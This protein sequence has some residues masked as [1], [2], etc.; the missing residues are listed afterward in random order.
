MTGDTSRHGR[1]PYG[2][3]RGD[4]DSTTE[5]SPAPPGFGDGTERWASQ[6]RI[7]AASQLRRREHWLRRQA[8]DDATMCG[9][10]VDHA[11]RRSVITLTTV[12][13]GRHTGIAVGAGAEVVVLHAGSTRI[14]VAIDAVATVQAT[15]IGHAPVNP[16]G[17]RVGDDP[18]TMA[19]LL[20]HA[21][22]DRPEITLVTRGGGAVE[23]E[24]RA[25]GRDLVMVRPERGALVYVRLASVSEA[26]LAVSTRSG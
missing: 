23:G 18:T 6:L 14:I 7:E 13:G 20:S 26:V 1:E 15:D 16:V 24:L 17:H 21:V 9:V 4:D 2:E 22:D 10:L 3:R 25:I 11:E 19:D 5:I 12:G 8:A